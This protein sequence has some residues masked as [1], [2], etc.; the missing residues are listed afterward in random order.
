[1]QN[2]H[3]YVILKIVNNK[4]ITITIILQINNSNLRRKLY[5]DSGKITYQI[6]SKTRYKKENA[7]T[8]GHF[9]RRV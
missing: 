2:L 6:K 3:Y 5:N 9:I 1:M 4:K 7:K 8:N